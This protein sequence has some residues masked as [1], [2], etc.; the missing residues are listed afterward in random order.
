M[1]AADCVV[2]GNPAYIGKYDM[3]RDV[4]PGGIFLLNCDWEGE[5]LEA[6]LPAEIKRAIA[7]KQ[8]KFYTCDAVNIARKIGL[9]GRINTIIQSAYFKL[10]DLIPAEDAIEYM[11]QGII[12]DYGAKG[13]NIV[14]MNVAAVLA[15]QTAAKEVSVPASWAN[16]QDGEKPVLQL[17][18]VNAE[19][20]A[21]VR[22]ILIPTNNLE[23]DAL[24]VS[25]FL[26]Y[27]TG[28]VPSGTAAF[29]KRGIAVDIPVWHAENCTQCNWCSTV[30]PHAVIRPFIL[31]PEDAQGL[32][33]VDCK[34]AP[35]KRFLIAVSAEDCTAAAPARRCAPP[36]A[37][38]CL[39]SALPAGCTTIRRPLS[40]PRRWASSRARARM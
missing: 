17:N 12:N 9:K 29:E 24:P 30:C 28:K 35:G 39:W 8:I 38:R 31:K 2:C 34:S 25:A 18:T 40:T 33:T 14:D 26:P 5:E 3:V 32:T 4:K 10:A 1:G 27:V 7:Q 15:G 13:Q 16:A 37:R 20:D 11:K 6:R 22:N 23:G 36:T 19:Q 21:Y